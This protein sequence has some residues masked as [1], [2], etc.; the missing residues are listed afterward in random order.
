[1]KFCNNQLPSVFL[2]IPLSRAGFE[3]L[4][5]LLKPQP[6]SKMNVTEAINHHW[7]TGET[8][9][10]EPSERLDTLIKSPEA[11][12]HDSTAAITV[13]GSGA[14]DP[15][16]STEYT[17]DYNT[18]THAGL[19][20]WRPSLSLEHPIGDQNS[21]V[22]RLEIRGTSEKRTNSSLDTVD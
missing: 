8:I 4:K 10:V 7:I 11:S 12:A 22:S 2:D 21:A 20:S 19:Q 9:P 6:G 3:F 15:L 18:I 16:Y 17:L 1:M 13:R 5:R 14:A